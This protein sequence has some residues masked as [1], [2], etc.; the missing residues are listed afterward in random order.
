MID[1]LP[2][3]CQVFQQDQKSIDAIKAISMFKRF[4]YSSDSNV[5]MILLFKRFKCTRD[6]NVEEI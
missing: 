4:K 6:L 2:K 1:P 5:Q 3:K